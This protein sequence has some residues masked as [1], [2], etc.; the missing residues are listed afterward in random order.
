MLAHGPKGRR[1][2]TLLLIV[3]ILFVAAAGG[4]LATLLEVA[5]WALLVMVLVGAGLGVLLW[6]WL[7]PRL[8][9]GDA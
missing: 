1:V 3:L 8:P 7:R 4:F 6:R 5:A 9:G 2:S